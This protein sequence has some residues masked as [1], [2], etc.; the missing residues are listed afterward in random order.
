[1]SVTTVIGDYEKFIADLKQKLEDE[2]IEISH[3]PIDHVCYRVATPEEYRITQAALRSFS[4]ELA[5]TV[6]NGREFS[7]F[8][9]VQP[10]VAVDF[11]IP[12]IELPSPAEGKP[13]AT[14]L[15]HMEVV[16]G[17]EFREFWETNRE[18]LTL[19]SDMEAANATARVTFADG[20]TVK[21]HAIPLDEAVR[22]QGDTFRAIE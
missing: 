5:V 17:E 12:L 3:Y 13:Y 11:N 15:E 8:R 2:G 14:G 10:L 19:D 18:R 9:L 21:F 1:M 4:S 6:H 22:L 16:I 20:R 7:I